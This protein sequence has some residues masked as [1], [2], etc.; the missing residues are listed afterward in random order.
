MAMLLQLHTSA[1]QELGL[2]A[3][4]DCHAAAADYVR[5][6]FW[7]L[8]PLPLVAAVF[9]ADTLCS[10]IIGRCRGLVFGRES[11]VCADG[12]GWCAAGAALCAACGLSQ[13]WR[14]LNA[15]GRGTWFCLAS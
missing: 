5:G 6:R 4:S 1:G 10:S 3:L 7:R 11:S 8:L 2:P 14:Q 9:H 13:Q 15:A 12:R